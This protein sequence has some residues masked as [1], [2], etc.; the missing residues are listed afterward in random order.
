MERCPGEKKNQKSWGEKRKIT[1]FLNRC[2]CLLLTAGHRYN[3]VCF[4]FSQHSPHRLGRGRTT[5]L[6]CFFFTCVVYSD[7]NTIWTAVRT[8]CVGPTLRYLKI[9]C[10]WTR[11]R[12]RNWIARFE[13]LQRCFHQNINLHHSFIPN[14]THRELQRTVRAAVMRETNTSRKRKGNLNWQ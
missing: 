11:A 1:T 6:L 10:R 13:H 7:T 8:G 3:C 14:P 4:H 2:C 9:Q 12:C 5:L